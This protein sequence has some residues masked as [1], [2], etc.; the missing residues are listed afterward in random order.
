MGRLTKSLGIR[1]FFLLLLVGIVVFVPM[2][3]LLIRANTHYLMDQIVANAKR[4]NHLIKGS[5]YY[6]M[7]KNQKED[8]AQIIN[9]LGQQPGVEGIRVYNKKGIISFSTDRAELGQTVD[10]KAERPAAAARTMTNM[11]IHCPSSPS[12]PPVPSTGLPKATKFR[13]AALIMISTA[14]RSLSAQAQTLRSAPNAGRV[15]IS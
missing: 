8:V 13:L 12:R 6:S 1:L 9:T 2:T 10:L 15:E 3:L 5:T 14:K 11:A 7:L 4:T